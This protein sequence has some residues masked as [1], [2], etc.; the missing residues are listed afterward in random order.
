MPFDVRRGDLITLELLQQLYEGHPTR[1]IRASGG[2]GARQTPDGQIQ[3]WGSATDGAFFAMP[4]STVAG[5]SGTWP[6]LTATSFTGDVYRQQNGKLKKVASS[7]K[8]W[9]GLPASLAASKVCTIRPDGA[10]DW[11]L[12]SQSCT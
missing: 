12:V 2:I 6:S 4:T 7:Q 3:I 8:I 10:G 1:G 11:S 9:N 5:A